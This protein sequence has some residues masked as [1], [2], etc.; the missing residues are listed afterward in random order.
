[1]DHRNNTQALKKENE[2]DISITSHLFLFFTIQ[3]SVQDDGY[4]T[5]NDDTIWEEHL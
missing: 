1:M 4:S 2:K 5:R 3:N